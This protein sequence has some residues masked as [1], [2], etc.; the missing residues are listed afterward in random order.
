MAA[1]PPVDRDALTHHLAVPKLW[2]EHG[3]IYEIPHTVFSYYPMNL[4]LLYVIPLL[5]GNDIAPK[6]IH[7][8]F[9]IGSAFL[10]FAYLRKRSRSDYALLG[11]LVFLSTPV[12]VKL[13]ISVYVDLGLIFFSWASLYYLFKWNRHSLRIHYLLVSAVFCGLALGTKYNG[14]L[15]L[16]LL[17]IAVAFIG[18]R[19]TDETKNAVALKG[20]LYPLLFMSVAIIIYSPWMIRNFKLTGNPIYPLYNEMIANEPTAEISMKPWLQRKLIYHETAMETA[21]IPIR[22]FIDG[23]DNSP[24]TFDGK[25]NPVLLLFP[26]LALFSLKKRN[27]QEKTELIVMGGFSFFFLIYASYIVD[28]RI[29]YISPI[30][31]PLAVM[32]VMG[33]KDAFAFCEQHIKVKKPISG[34]LL[35]VCLLVLLMQNVIYINN[36]FTTVQPISFLNGTVTRAEYIETFR[37]EYP[38]IQ[39]ANELSSENIKIMA[40]F[41]GNR[42]YYFNQ[43]VEF[44]I[45]RFK[46]KVEGSDMAAD[47]TD[48]ISLAGFTHVIVGAQLFNDWVQKSFDIDQLI[49]VRDFFSD[50]CR[51]VFTKNGYVLYEILK[52]TES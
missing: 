8:L 39:V 47:L 41:I 13:S 29:R 17:I 32:S 36:L 38:T 1:V 3:G 5:F 30:L 35:V 51:A 6:Y 27:S 20:F 15:V 37:P 4:D 25:L 14:L 28:M 19:N 50:H 42:R 46:Q 43:P 44:A 22:V 21:L 52:N 49:V 40:L 24:K 12:I 34:L 7:F 26:L 33:I 31:P 9:G 48:N 16:L 23:E 2:I 11:V 45:D 18:S 10:I